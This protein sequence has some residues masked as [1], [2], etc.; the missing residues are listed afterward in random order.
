MIR[1]LLVLLALSLAACSPSPSDSP[2]QSASPDLYNVVATTGMIGDIVQSVAGDRAHVSVIIGPGTDPHTYVPSRQDLAKLMEADIL[3]HNGLYL[4]G[5]MSDSL[6]RLSAS[7]PVHAVTALLEPES[8]L[9]EE[10]G[11]ATDPH[12][13]MDVQLWMLATRAVA[14]A[15]AE[16]DPPHAE[17]YRSNAESFILQLGELDDYARQSFASIPSESRMLITAHDAFR[18]MARAYEF[19]VRGIQGISTSSEAGLMDIN[20][21]V[22]LIVER[23]IP[24]VFPESTIA[25][26]NVRALVEG[27][28]SR[29]HE[30]RIGAYLFSDAM[31]KPGTYEGTYIGMI[32]HNVTSITRALGGDAPAAG[33]HGKLAQP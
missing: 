1:L 22:D 23:R 4:E 7:R 14:K 31:G 11:Q 26:R 32:D 28:G 5:R 27:A 3:F 16:F 19:E 24:T 30:V 13:W 2:R 15:L 10:N 33:L 18:Y 17:K 21:L 20:R 9:H 25:D 8:L 29:G 6:D 12:V